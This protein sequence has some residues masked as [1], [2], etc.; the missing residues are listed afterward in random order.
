MIS[1]FTLMGCNQYEE[2]DQLSLYNDGLF[3][4][5][6]KDNLCGYLD[7]DME[8]AIPF[9][10]KRVN[11]F[12]NGLAIVVNEDNKTAVINKK[13]EEVI[14][15]AIQ[16]VELYPVEKLIKI[17]KS[18]NFEY[19]NYR[20]KT[21][22]PREFYYK[23]DYPKTILVAYYD[24]ESRCFGYNDVFDNEKIPCTFTNVTDNIFLENTIVVIDDLRYLIDKTGNKVINKGFTA[25]ANSNLAGYFTVKDSTKGW[26]VINSSGET[27]IPFEYTIPLVLSSEGVAIATKETGS[28]IVDV[29]GHLIHTANLEVYV[30]NQ[31]SRYFVENQSVIMYNDNLN[32]V[33][34]PKGEI[35]Y[36]SEKKVVNVNDKY[37]VRINDS[38]TSYSLYDYDDNEL[39]SNY[40]SITLAKNNHDL[41][42]C[43]KK[44]GIVQQD[45][46]DSELNEISPVFTKE[47]VYSDFVTNYSDEIFLAFQNT[48]DE[49][50]ELLNSDFETIYTIES[51]ARYTIY[52]DGYIL[53]TINKDIIIIDF[54][55][56]ELL[57]TAV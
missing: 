10:Y 1:L 3:G 47:Y 18:K 48:T 20:G 23:L 51:Q 45:V 6:N 22:L 55:G 17:T 13:G 35:A 53:I 19:Y 25:S 46:Y 31:I 14:S 26:G 30:T 12:Q 8:V 44:D 41:I 40:N 50:Y 9:T 27:V 21:V 42:I 34:T 7:E 49:V 33:F 52:Q 4:M 57:N 28:G 38:N 29:E 24:S 16:E 36:L 43:Q 2:T 15:A 11:P 32:Y 5:C 56:N 37:V 39:I 54:S